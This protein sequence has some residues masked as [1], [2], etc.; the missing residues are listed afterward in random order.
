M[1]KAMADYL[2]YAIYFWAGDG[3]EPV[4]VH[5]AKGEPQEN[6]TK[7]WIKS[8][9]VELAHNNGNVPTRDLKSLLNFIARNRDDVVLKWL[10]IF[11]HADYKK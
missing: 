2:G 5:I 3:A 9:G 6:A 11:K 7:I 4:H 10:D 8:D 1:P